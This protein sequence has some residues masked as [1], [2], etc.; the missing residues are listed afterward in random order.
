MSGLPSAVWSGGK[1]SLPFELV[2]SRTAGWSNRS[3]VVPRR[4]QPSVVS[5]DCFLV[6]PTTVSLAAFELAVR[7]RPIQAQY[8]V[9][10]TAA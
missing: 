5:F 10:F 6:G 3:V 4:Q 1:V 2:V 9:P 8:M 7:R